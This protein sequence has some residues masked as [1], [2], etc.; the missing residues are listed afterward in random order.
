MNKLM[1]TN[2]SLAIWANAFGADL[3]QPVVI[4]NLKTVYEIS[5]SRGADPETMQAMLLRETKGGI[6][7]MVGASHLPPEQR[8]Y[9]LMQVQLV[10]A[11]SVLQRWPEISE[12]Y[13]KGRKPSQGELITKLTHDKEFNI[14]IASAHFVTYLNLSKGDWSKA[15]AAYNMGI[16]NA[17]KIT[18]HNRY[19]YVVWIRKTIDRVIKPFNDKNGL[20]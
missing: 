16:G 17:N 11:R 18:N 3:S 1:L 4:D 7:S 6:S 15:V 10:A 20:D 9:G 13:F 19:E 14:D 12:V 8:S 5:S 2:M